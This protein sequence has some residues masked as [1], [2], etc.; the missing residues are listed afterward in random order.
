MA[1]S[2]DKPKEGKGKPKL[3]TKEKQAKKK[4][5]KQGKWF[6]LEW[7]RLDFQFKSLAPFMPQDPHP[8]AGSIFWFKPWH[9][10]LF[11][12]TYLKLMNR[13][14]RISTLRKTGLSHLRE[15]AGSQ[16]IIFPST[17]WTAAITKRQPHLLPQS[18]QKAFQHLSFYL[19]SLSASTPMVFGFIEWTAERWPGEWSRWQ[20]HARRRFEQA[21]VDG[22]KTG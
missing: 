17:V 22:A 16:F 12:R 4:E 11:Y 6:A 20:M 15:S 13:S 1:K 21:Q 3:T 10:S 7:Q 19:Q 9:S 14:L 8:L 18:F 5:K 2:V